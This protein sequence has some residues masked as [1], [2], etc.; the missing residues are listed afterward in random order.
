MNSFVIRTIKR[1]GIAMDVLIDSEDASFYDS[2]IWN[3]SKKNGYPRT[4]A[5][6]N[7]KRRPYFHL[8]VLGFPVGMEVDHKNT[9]KL[10]CRKS[11][12]RICSH[13]KNRMNQ[14]PHLGRRFVGVYKRKI[15][16]TFYALIINKGKKESLGTFATEKEA[17]IARDRRAKELCG[18][19]AYLNFPGE[20][21][22]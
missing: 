9:N 10:D 22:Q 20:V 18:E 11:N 4:M 6:I 13:D 19:F 15:N 12:L 5:T 14:K 16:G 17:A 7:G 21:S 1:K 3:L 2:Y 8:A